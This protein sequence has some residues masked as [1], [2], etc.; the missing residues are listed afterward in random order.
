MKRVVIALLLISCLAAG[1]RADVFDSL[2]SAD[3]DKYVHFCAGTVL[4][5]AS[6]PFFRK[7][8]KN[9]DSAWL[10]SLGLALLFSAG[11]ELHDSRSTGF[12][13]TDLL[14]GAAGGAT[15]VVV[16]F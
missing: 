10:Y 1:A 12:S 6:Y 16:K 8:L 5:H 2:A 13:G 4:S 9:K 7:R 14:A 15:I 11:K 3:K